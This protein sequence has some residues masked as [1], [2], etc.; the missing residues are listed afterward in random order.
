[1][2]ISVTCSSMTCSKALILLLLW[3]FST[4]LIG[5]LVLKPSSY[6]QDVNV[7]TLYSATG[8][9][10]FIFLASPFAGFLADMK[11]GR[12]KVL[13]FSTY[14]MIASF[15][16][17]LLVLILLAFTIHRS[18][19]YTYLNIL[20]GMLGAVAFVYL[21]GR[22]IF[23]VNIV[24][25]AMDQL[26]DAPTTNS[27]I[28]L[29]HYFWINN[30]S[31]L[32]AKSVNVLIKGVNFD[33][34]VKKEIVFPKN[35][36]FILLLIGLVS[37]ISSLIILY[38][39]HTNIMWF[40]SDKITGNPYK[41]IYSVVKFACVNKRPIRRSAFT[42]CE[43]EIP[44]RLDL[45]KQKYGGP[46]TTEQ[47]EDVKVFL[48]MLKL[49][50]SLSPS[51]VLHWGA[52]ISVA[53]SYKNQVK[54]DIEEL[55][56]NHGLI[57]PVLS[58]LAIPVYLYIVR[59]YAARYIPNLFKRIG[60]NIAILYILFLIL[61]VFD[62]IAFQ[63]SEE[64]GDFLYTCYNTYVLNKTRANISTRYI[65]LVQH[66]FL[67]LHEM[68]FYIAAWEFICCQSPQNM[69]GF[70]FGMFYAIRALLQFIAIGLILPFFIH[71]K[72][73]IMSCR[74]GYYLTNIGIGTISLIIFTFFARRYQY[75]K[76][77]DICNVYQYAEDY[78]SNIQ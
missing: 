64:L 67:P 34:L 13:V 60:L 69:K 37:I 39:I 50:L 25:F 74:S 42:Y 44:S 15:L 23:T 6:T 32:F 77:D 30:L 66:I 78:Y 10:A 54:N 56:L 3:D 1:M 47:V 19:N 21:F 17:F 76:R 41:V 58:L 46:L 61:L 14:I 43:D 71:W 8:A 9:I 45:G 51:F 2:K 59:P 62:I 28:F 72:S 31:D 26:R 36:A 16:S 49:I 29:H 57:S 24:Q 68:L 4:N 48:H 73:H 55:F 27:I 11:F 33:T 63:N 20:E 38:L 22:M 7:A 40:I 35:V 52:T 12:L 5:N 70:V 65:F 53:L 75:R 18:T